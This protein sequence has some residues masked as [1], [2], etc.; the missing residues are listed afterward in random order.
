LIDAVA[1][2]LAFSGRSPVINARE[3]NL[4]AAE[5]AAK[6]A[7]APVESIR[8]EFLSLAARWRAMAVRENFLG[9]LGAPGLLSED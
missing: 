9:Q 7:S 4:R 1:F 3:C 2:H 8:L 5:C 6:A